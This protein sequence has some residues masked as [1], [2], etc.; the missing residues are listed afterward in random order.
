MRIA[1]YLQAMG[2]KFMVDNIVNTNQTATVFVNTTGESWLFTKNASIDVTGQDGISE[3]GSGNVMTVRSD[4]NVTGAAFAGL[5][6]QG[7][8]SV[9]LVGGASLIDASAAMAGI[10]YDGIGGSITVD[11]IIEG[12][13]Y[14][15]HGDFSALVTNNGTLIGDQGIVFERSHCR[16]TNSGMIDA[17]ELAIGTK[18][19]N[20]R[21]FNL[22]G[23]VIESDD[24][25][26][27]FH[28]RGR[29]RIFNE[30]LIEADNIAIQSDFGKMKVVNS[31]E[32]IGDVMLGDGADK[33]HMHKGTL[34]GTVFGGDGD[35]IYLLSDASV[36]IVENAGE[37]ND[38][39]RSTVSYTLGNNLEDLIL[40]AGSG[41]TDGKGNALGNHITGSWDDNVLIGKGGKDT[42]SGHGGNDLLL[43]GNG[44][45]MFV[46]E[47]G[48]VIIAD[49]TDGV[50]LLAS[51]LVGRVQQFEHLQA[52]GKIK[53]IGNDVRIDFAGDTEVLLR[54]FDK[55]DLDYGDFASSLS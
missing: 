5:R 40:A 17:S 25:G 34:D 52:N 43:G 51:Y 49:F 20:T 9:L 48:H 31:G 39:I 45:D 27:A 19:A 50:D 1:S 53:Q 18:T 38:L 36:P 54:N 26:L 29:T 3:T 10:Q 44:A 23:G 21:I 4:I 22:E 33:F 42:L 41:N 15:I 32:I 13:D 14:A 2:G 12:G 7:A 11:G 8:D 47:R 24:I 55:A 37:G 6:F 30:G 46:F 35:D 28:G 16:I